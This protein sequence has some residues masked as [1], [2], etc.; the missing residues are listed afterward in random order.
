VIRLHRALARAGVASR[1]HAET[2]IAAGRVKVNGNVARVGQGIDPSVDHVTLDGRDVPMGDR[3]ESW[4]VLHKPARV[5]TTRS[6]P[7]GRATVFD[8]VDDAP[9]LTYVGRLDFDT[10]GVLLLTTDG[11]AVHRLTHP[12]NRVERVYVATVVGDAPAAAARAKA[13][14]ALSDGTVQ[15]LRVSV[16]S[17]PG[18]RWEFEVVIAEGRKREVRRLCKALQLVVE[19]L[20]R[21]QFGPVKLGRLAAGATRQL[22]PEEREALAVLTARASP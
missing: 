3:E 2:M 12:S 14:V 6:D 18:G 15:P 8:Y 16:R 10:E 1:R 4:I 22:S 19:R 13:G 5:M 20:V 17:A 7:Q 9:G 21:T 11:D